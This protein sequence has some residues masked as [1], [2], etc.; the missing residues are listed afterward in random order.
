MTTFEEEK[1]KLEEEKD[2]LLKEKEVIKVRHEVEQLK[3]SLKEPSSFGKI[4]N[5]WLGGAKV[6]GRG[7]MKVGENLSKHDTSEALGLKHKRKDDKQ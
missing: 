1:K 6:V 3:K 7:L 5:M 2:K 4:G